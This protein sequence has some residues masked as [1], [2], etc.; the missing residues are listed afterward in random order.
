MDMRIHLSDERQL[1]VDKQKAQAPGLERFRVIFP[2]RRHCGGYGMFAVR[3]QFDP[4][5]A[6]SDFVAVFSRTEPS[7]RWRAGRGTH[8]RAR[9]EW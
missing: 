3:Y 8:P 2:D 5:V 7:R 1:L 6:P 9:T 4:D